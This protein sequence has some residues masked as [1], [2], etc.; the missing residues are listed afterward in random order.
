MKYRINWG[1]KF[2]NRIYPLNLSYYFAPL[3]NQFYTIRDLLR[4]MGAHIL[5]QAPFS[6]FSRIE[7]GLVHNYFERK[8]IVTRTIDHKEFTDTKESYNISSYFLKYVWDNTNYLNGNRTFLKYE[9]VPNI[10]D[11]DFVYKKIKF[12]TRSYVTISRKS[13]IILATRLFLSRSTGRN[14]RLFGIGGSDMNTFFLSGNTVLNPIYKN[15]I[16]LDTEYQYFFMNNFEVFL[17]ILFG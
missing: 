13:H 16:M 10:G 11:N 12:D 5:F 17:H 2:Y 4:D 8:E 6:K 7:G 1:T 3:D 14:A 9:V 15:D